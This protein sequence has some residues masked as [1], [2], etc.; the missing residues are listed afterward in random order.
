MSLLT[1][2]RLTQ[3]NQNTYC[4]TWSLDNTNLHYMIEFNI[5]LWYIEN[6]RYDVIPNYYGKAGMSS[7]PNIY[8]YIY[9][10]YLSTYLCLISTDCQSNIKNVGPPECFLLQ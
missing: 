2:Y 7:Q 8:G 3:S 4:I 9:I 1:H 5:C 6:G 10:S